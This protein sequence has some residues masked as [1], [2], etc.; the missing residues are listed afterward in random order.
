MTSLCTSRDPK[1][2]YAEKECAQCGAMDGLSVTPHDN[3]NGAAQM[4][5]LQPCARCLTTFYCSIRCQQIH[6]G[7]QHRIYCVPRRFPTAATERARQAVRNVRKESKPSSQLHEGASCAICEGLQTDLSMMRMPCGHNYHV[8]C[9]RGLDMHGLSTPCPACCE[10]FPSGTPDALFDEAIRRL[11][12]LK[13][14]VR[15][16]SLDWA[17]LPAYEQVELDELV[18]MLKGAASDDG[19]GWVTKWR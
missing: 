2:Q 16:R 19:V 12:C 1:G 8:E 6:W 13:V 10:R 15:A 17:F 11:F 4:V 3:V 18:R 14:K 9:V 7:R 5:R